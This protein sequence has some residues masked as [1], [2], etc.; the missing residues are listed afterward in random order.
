VSD[1]NMK[2]TVDVMVEYGGLEAKAKDE[3]KGYYT[4]GYLPGG[5][6]S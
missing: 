2:D 6:G 5:S 1:A 3:Y 4:N